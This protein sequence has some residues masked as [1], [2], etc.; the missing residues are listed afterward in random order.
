MAAAECYGVC[1]V[2]V[3][4]TTCDKLGTCVLLIRTIFRMFL[5][6]VGVF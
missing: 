4:S 6:D 2:I 5:S 1:V 3:T